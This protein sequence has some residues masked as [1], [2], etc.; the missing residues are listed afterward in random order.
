LPTTFWPKNLLIYNIRRDYGLITSKVHMNLRGANNKENRQYDL[1][2]VMSKAELAGFPP[3]PH[4]NVLSQHPE[5][6]QSSEIQ[7]KHDD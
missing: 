7:D 4:P 6:P 1:H 5:S 2:I 3:S